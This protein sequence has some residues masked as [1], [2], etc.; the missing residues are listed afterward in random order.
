MTA[1]V[2]GHAPVSRTA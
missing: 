1:L 2:S